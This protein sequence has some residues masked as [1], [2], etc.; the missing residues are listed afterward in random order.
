ML[1]IGKRIKTDLSVSS[2]ATKKQIVTFH[3]DDS[4][5]KILNLMYKHNIRKLLLENTNQF[6]SDRI[7]IGEISKM[8]KLQENPSESFLDM[9]VSMFK[10]EYIKVIRDLNLSQ[11]CTIMDKMDHPYVMH[12]DIIVTPWDVCLALM[13]DRLIEDLVQISSSHIVEQRV[14][15]HCG[16]VI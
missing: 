9:P 1:E 6:I 4:V 13:S 11:L 7:I 14:C 8:L 16:K 5:G 12:K 2:I 15:P 10:L 3:R